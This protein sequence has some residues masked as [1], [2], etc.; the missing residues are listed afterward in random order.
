MVRGKLFVITSLPPSPGGP[1]LLHVRMTM[2]AKVYGAPVF[3]E[4][5]RVVGV[6]A[7]SA[8]PAAEQ[9]EGELNLHYVP[10]VDPLLIRA[11]LEQRDETLWVPPTLPPVKAVGETEPKTP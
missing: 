5:G 3:N 7:E 10:V 8:A 4:A 9:A 11:W 1:R 2:A 6:F